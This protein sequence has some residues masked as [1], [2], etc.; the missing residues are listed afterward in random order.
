MFQR[1]VG[2]GDVKLEDMM[3]MLGKAP[4]KERKAMVQQRLEMFLEMPDQ[5]RIES[6]KE[7]ITAL[8]KLPDKQRKAVIQ[9]RTEVMASFPTEQRAK[10]FKSRMMAGQ[11]VPPE[12]HETDMKIT[13]ESVPKLSANLRKNFMETKEALM[14]AMP[15]MA[16]AAKMAPPAKP[17]I[18]THHDRPM[19]KKGWFTKNYVCQVCGHKI[20]A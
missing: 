8:S 13:E 14:K 5:K 9:T 17:G 4:A 10:L 19:A 3:K 2:S 18:P 12:I 20:P 16:P 7:L 11:Q 15:A 1:I 6:I